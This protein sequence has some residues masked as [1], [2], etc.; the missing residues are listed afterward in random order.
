MKSRVEHGLIK[1]V[2]G[3]LADFQLAYPD[4][5]TLDRDLIRL[6]R[7]CESRGVDTFLRLLP[8]VDSALLE[9]LKTGTL[10]GKGPFLRRKSPTDHRPRFMHGLWSTILDSRACLL[11]EVDPFSIFTLRQVALVG[12]KLDLPCKPANIQQELDNYARIDRNLRKP[13]LDWQSDSFDPRDAHRRIHFRDCM[14]DRVHPGFWPEHN[15]PSNND[16]AYELLENFQRVCDWFASRLPSYSPF[17]GQCESTNGQRA[18]RGS[19]RH[20]IGAVAEGTSYTDKYDVLYYPNKMRL[21]HGTHYAPQYDRTKLVNHEPPSRVLAVPKD[22]R[23]PRLI[24]AEPIAHMWGQQNLRRYLEE[25]I[26]RLVGDFINFK[27]QSLS[28]EMARRGS[29]DGSLA[30]VDLSSASDRLSTWTVERAF[31]RAPQLLSAIH[32]VRTRWYRITNVDGTVDHDRFNKI[33]SQG[34]AITFPL[35]SLVFLLACISLAEGSSWKEKLDVCRG[36]VR[37]FGDDIVIPSHWYADLELLLTT[38]ELKVNAEKSF[39]TGFFRESCGGDFYRGYDVTPVKITRLDPTS[40]AGLQS[41]RDTSNNLFRKGLWKASEVVRS[42]D[43][44]RSSVPISGI[45]AGV[46]GYLSFCG[47]WY[48]HLAMRWEPR[49]QRVE[50]KANVLSAKVD[51]LPRKGLSRLTMSL[52]EKPYRFEEYSSDINGRP[53]VRNRTRWVH[54]EEL[55]SFRWNRSYYM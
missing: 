3:I 4:Y 51:P 7:S 8:H 22:A 42:L 32:S 26:A 54:L 28:Q 17:C 31:R 53:L 27:S 38:L 19:Y 55:T 25:N 18:E 45:T 20:G 41:I 34:T 49:L 39:H 10:S 1:V 37:T 12:K 47:S 30:T 24:A 11:E 46:P 5:D 21:V 9:C 16:R 50:Y 44:Y 40:P 6:T 52:I 33:L 48:N 14:D 2:A 43:R 15:G 36:K 35:Q 13:S 29:V 23:K